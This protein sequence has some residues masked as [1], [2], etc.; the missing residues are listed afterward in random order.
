MELTADQSQALL[1]DQEDDEQIADQEQL[2]EQAK[3]L[4]VK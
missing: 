3:A 4:E 1:H 2:L